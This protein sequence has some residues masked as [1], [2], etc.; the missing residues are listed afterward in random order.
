MSRR[1]KLRRWAQVDPSPF[2]FGPDGGRMSHLSDAELVRK[3]RELRE[4]IVAE[5][6]EDEAKRIEDEVRRRR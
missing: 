6:G 4:T 3:A 1:R 5:F 2:R